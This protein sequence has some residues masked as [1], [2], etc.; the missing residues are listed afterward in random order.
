M[1]A[2]RF[3]A[4]TKIA[5]FNRH[6]KEI[7]VDRIWLVRDGYYHMPDDNYLHDEDIIGFYN[8]GK[9]II[10]DLYLK[11]RNSQLLLLNQE[12]DAAGHWMENKDR[13]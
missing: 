9:R 10:N 1:S 3:T 5:Y 2:T 7:V 6:T 13:N 11:D 4:N 12:L 8:D